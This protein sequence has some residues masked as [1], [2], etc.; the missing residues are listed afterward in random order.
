MRLSIA[1]CTYNG[2]TFL[3]D[4]LQSLAAQTRQPDELVVCDDASSDD[5]CAILDAFAAKAPF[6]VRRVRNQTN[7][8][9]TKNFDQAIGLC[10]GDIIALCDQ[11]DVWRHDKLARVESA[12]RKPAVGLAF[13]DA[14]VVDSQLRSIS[15][16][17][18]AIVSLDAPLQRQ[19]EEGDALA[20]LIAGWFV[21]GATMAFRAR[22]RNL[23]L[24][25]P[26]DLTL[27]H[28]GWIAAVVATVARVGCI[29]ECLIRYREHPAQ[30]IGPPRKARVP[31]AR[32]RALL[33]RLNPYAEQI[34]VARRLEERVGRQSAFPLRTG[35]KE[36]LLG[37]IAHY[38][39]RSTLPSRRVARLPLVLRELMSR[40]Y[41]RY[42]NGLASA[43]KDLVTS[44]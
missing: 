8:G 31:Q 12:F 13:S 16:S 42:S 17:L 1:M 22:F 27:V 43:A 15:P 24:P 40:R 4:Q 34:A 35:V 7:I 28:D 25:I 29:D 39:A 30:L 14:E 2:A 10:S 5:T 41:H 38:Q 11:D 37:R 36:Q 21:T 6:S 20:V 23:A 9:A 18:W 32:G 3:R 44:L 19:I 26:S 33:E